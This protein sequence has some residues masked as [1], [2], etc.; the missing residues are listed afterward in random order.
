MTNGFPTFMKI[1]S[2]QL[3][4]MKPVYRIYEAVPILRQR[5]W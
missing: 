5:F 1:L 2:T 3:S 4:N